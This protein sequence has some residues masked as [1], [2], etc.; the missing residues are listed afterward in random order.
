MSEQV[1]AAMA[2]VVELLVQHHID[3][4]REMV[5]KVALEMFEKEV[6]KSVGQAAISTADYY[7]IVR[8]GPELVIRVQIDA[9]P[10]KR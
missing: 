9:K 10:G 3:K 7:S 6:R 1:G 2:G 5:I 8:E 4:A